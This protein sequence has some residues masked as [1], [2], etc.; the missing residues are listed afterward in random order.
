MISREAFLESIGGADE[1]FAG[2]VRRTLAELRQKEE[3]PVKKKISVGLVMATAILLLGSAALAMSM[4]GI[5][6]RL[7]ETGRELK[8]YQLIRDVPQRVTENEVMD[9]I[10]EEALC[11]SDMFYMT[12]CFTPKQPD[13]LIVPFVPDITQPGTAALMNNPEIDPALTLADYAQQFGFS[14]VVSFSPLSGHPLAG[15]AAI[16]R[17]EHLPDG[18]LRVLME[19]PAAPQ[20]QTYPG[21]LVPVRWNVIAYAYPSSGLAVEAAQHELTLSVDIPMRVNDLGRRSTATDAHAIAH[22]QGYVQWIAVERTEQGYAYFNMLVDG[23]ASAGEE[24][25]MYMPYA[26]LI[27]EDGT[28]LHTLNCTRTMLA[29]TNGEQYRCGLPSEYAEM[30]RMTIRL[31]DA[32]TGQVY[33]EYTYTME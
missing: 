21:M 26:Q 27:A 20:T 16:A 13:T 28:V 24:G 31:L 30:S 14:Q 6:D 5:S 18:S 23:L 7:A 1:A 29:S 4:W 11:D 2:H 22:A 15:E 19:G 3:K 33:D 9:L 8:P 32:S 25:S 12:L 17:C 10:V